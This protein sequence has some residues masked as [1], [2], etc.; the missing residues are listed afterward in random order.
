MF[1]G[2]ITLQYDNLEAFVNVVGEA[3]NDSNVYL[4][5]NYVPM[6]EAYIE[7]TSQQSFKIVNKSHVPVEFE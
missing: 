3:H 5:K 7:L 1:R 6:K 2:E 4:S